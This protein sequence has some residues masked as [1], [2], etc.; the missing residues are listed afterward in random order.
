MTNNDNFYNKKIK[1]EYLKELKRINVP[2]SAIEHTRTVFN[3]ST[4]FENKLKKDIAELSTYE[5]TALFVHNNWSLSYIFN[6]RQTDIKKY[7]AWYCSN[8]SS[9]NTDEI[10]NLTVELVA[11][12]TDYKNFY[13]GSLESLFDIVTEVLS[14]IKHDY[15]YELSFKVF[16]GLIWYK[17]PYEEMSI[18]TRENFMEG[19]I[20]INN[21]VYQISSELYEMCIDLFGVDECIINAKKYFQK[22]NYLLRAVLPS[23]TKAENELEPID[24]TVY[25][26]N[27]KKAWKKY[28][29]DLPVTSAFKNCRLDKKKI[30]K[31]GK[32]SRIYE[33]Y[34][35]EDKEILN[36]LIA[37][38]F[39]IDLKYANRERTSY[40]IWKKYF[41]N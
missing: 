2:D 14:V 29:E 34:K 21:N 41:H 24:L 36:K 20:K 35:G 3:K 39:N 27:K 15:Y 40:L 18:L 7:V 28:T 23:I 19:K 31:S 9:V 12:G 6:N 4:F 22:N 25:F 8:I 16:L 11:E 17:V 38:E 37:K 1:D 33:Q 32:F 10:V 5:F 13:F 30:E 26:G